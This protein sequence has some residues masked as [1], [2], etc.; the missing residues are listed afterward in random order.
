MIPTVIPVF[1]IFHIVGVIHE[2]KQN[3]C[4]IRS[5]GYHTK[6]AGKKSKLYL[7]ASTARHCRAVLI[8]IGN[9][10]ITKS[11]KRFIT[12]LKPFPISITIFFA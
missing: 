6:L 7:V 5:T 12:T 1:Q 2:C 11:Q 10:N 9:Y 4:I 3:T 8:V